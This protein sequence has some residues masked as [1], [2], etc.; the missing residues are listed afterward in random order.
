MQ[1]H[2]G[3][4]RTGNNKD[5]HKYQSH[6]SSVYNTLQSLIEVCKSEKYTRNQNNEIDRNSGEYCLQKKH[7]KSAEKNFFADSGCESNKRKHEPFFFCPGKYLNDTCLCLIRKQLFCFF[8]LLRAYKRKNSLIQKKY[9]AESIQN[10]RDDGQP[11]VVL[12]IEDR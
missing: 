5:A 6:Y 8:P 1:Y 4:Q 7:G 12:K 2:T 9:T 11:G 3:N 10:K